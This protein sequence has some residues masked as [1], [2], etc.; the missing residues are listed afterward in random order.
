MDKRMDGWVNA[1]KYRHMDEGMVGNAGTG[2]VDTE[3]GREVAG[4]LAGDIEGWMDARVDSVAGNIG[5]WMNEGVNG[6][7][8]IWRT[9]G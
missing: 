3:T 7:T 8:G 1:Y 4:W 6:N 2:M 5:M 9:N